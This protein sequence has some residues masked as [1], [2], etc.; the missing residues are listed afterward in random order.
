[1]IKSFWMFWLMTWGA[2][3]A[4]PAQSAT[5]LESLTD[6]QHVLMIRHADAPGFSDP[7]GF[8]L[9]DCSTQRNLG[10]RGRQQAQA[11]GI[12]LKRQ[13]VDSA[14]VLSSAWCRCVDTATL[15]SKGP[16]KIEP[17]LGSFFQNVSESGPQTAALR[18]LLS[19]RL[20]EPVPRKPLILVTHQVNISAYTGESVGQGDVMLV[21]VGPQGQYLS[22]RLISVPQ[23]N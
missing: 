6:G 17:S 22:H 19:K 14:E 12:W 4:Y 16:V 13:G 10:E 3:F 20:Q 1:M 5:L 9:G 15:I 8:K 7:P 23:Q 18:V 11:L 2:L 21:K